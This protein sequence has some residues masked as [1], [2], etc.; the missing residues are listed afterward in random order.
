MSTPHTAHTAHHGHPH[1][2]TP[3]APRLWHSYA[4]TALIIFTCIAGRGLGLYGGKVFPTRINTMWVVLLALVTYIPFIK[5][6]GAKALTILVTLGLFAFAIEY[7]AVTKCFLYGCFAYGDILGTKILGAIPRTLFFSR[8]PLIL[9]VARIVHHIRTP[10][11]CQAL[12]GG[13][14]LVFVDMLINP[15]AVVSGF[16]AFQDIGP[17]YGIPAQ[18]FIWRLV[19]G[20]IGTYLFLTLIHDAHADTSLRTDY[21]RWS[22]LL[23]VLC[24][25]SAAFTLSLRWP[26]AIGSIILLYFGYHLYKIPTT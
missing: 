13:V 10:L 1:A 12:I 19:S 9:G 18:N 7:V 25:T 23:I 17:W 22:F 21:L 15:V 26:A 11:R 8:T 14:A 16:R 4:A 24:F 3:S 20:T 5:K 6:H 2:H